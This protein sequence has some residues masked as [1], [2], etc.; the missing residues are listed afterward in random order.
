MRKNLKSKRHHIEHRLVSFGFDE[1][2]SG[3]GAQASKGE[4]GSPAA[5]HR[6]DEEDSREESKYRDNQSEEGED[7]EA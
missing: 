3:E 6:D 7:D 5:F 2:S 4:S 1:D